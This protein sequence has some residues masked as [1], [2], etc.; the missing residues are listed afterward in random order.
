MSI[1]FRCPLCKK[2]LKVGDR[3]RGQQRPCPGC[4]KTVTIPMTSSRTAGQSGRR[5]A[6][7]SESP[8]DSQA[9]RHSG[10]QAEGNRQHKRLQTTAGQTLW[11]EWSAKLGKRTRPALQ[12][13][14][15]RLSPALTRCGALMEAA[16]KK[17]RSEAAETWQFYAR[18][19]EAF[20][21]FLQ[22]LIGMSHAEPEVRISQHDRTRNCRIRADNWFIRL[23]ECC[24][25]CGEETENDP[26]QKEQSLLDIRRTLE[27]IGGG[28]LAALVFLY[29]DIS[30]WVWLPT[31][32]AGFWLGCRARRRVA[33][34]LVYKLCETHADDKEPPTVRLLR[35]RTRNLILRVGSRK[36][37][38]TAW[39]WFFR[40]PE[41]K[42]PAALPTRNPATDQPSASVGVSS[43][44]SEP[45]P[46]EL[47]PIPLV[48]DVDGDTNIVHRERVYSEDSTST[49]R[50][51]IPDRLPVPE[52]EPSRLEPLDPE[53][54]DPEPAETIAPATAASSPSQ[55]PVTSG[56]ETEQEGTRHRHGSDE[57][58][59][60]VAESSDVVPETVVAA[61]ASLAPNLDAVSDSPIESGPILK[62]QPLPA[63]DGK[64]EEALV[65][66]RSSTGRMDPETIKLVPA[67]LDDDSQ[68]VVI[69]WPVAS[70]ATVTA[71]ILEPEKDTNTYELTG[72]TSPA[73]Q[74]SAPHDN[75]SEPTQ[76]D[77]RVDVEELNKGL[78][79]AWSQLHLDASPCA[80]CG[81]VMPTEEI[82]FSGRIMLL[83]AVQHSP[84]AVAA[85]VQT[86]NVYFQG[87]Y[88][89]TDDVGSFCSSVN[90]IRHTE[91][92]ACH[93]FT[94][95]RCRHR[96][97][98]A[99][100][101]LKCD[102]AGQVS[103]P[104]APQQDAAEVEPTVSSTTAAATTG[105]SKSPAQ[106][107]VDKP[108]VL[109]R[110]TSGLL[111]GSLIPWLAQWRQAEL[112]RRLQPLFRDADER[113]SVD[114]REVSLEALNKAVPTIEKVVEFCESNLAQLEQFRNQPTQFWSL[115]GL[116]V[117]TGGVGL[118]AGLLSGI[119]SRLSYRLREKKYWLAGMLT[120]L[121]GSVNFVFLLAV[122][123][124]LVG[125][126]VF[127]LNQVP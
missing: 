4:G 55:T 13:M 64:E 109:R 108:R 51:L 41:P 74:T 122:Y 34:L 29:Y 3:L 106:D 68:P 103:E 79:N 69:L 43:L 112:T 75:A 83:S 12:A 23:P 86:V 120:F 40:E 37:R 70:E 21:E 77:N 101:C 42:P 30:F 52:T 123:V 114:L 16:W 126:V 65:E 31:I 100:A 88:F 58:S 96:Y 19:R 33:G 7:K 26:I 49:S 119:L 99:G 50:P 20:G 27:W 17:V 113:I 59:D 63:A 127:Y 35:T 25:V 15:K 117:L 80:C 24:A 98:G 39:Q 78:T 45:S 97:Q 54:T 1:Q 93:S 125:A 9:S 60:V 10:G 46:R 92:A 6:G 8:P 71:E 105:E 48:D 82:G 118:S 56:T 66:I 94:C 84:G 121:M 38:R 22:D 57:N 89:S 124:T 28:L 116:A 81:I 87:N 32:V 104:V 53:P 44:P 62:P 90:Q 47:S 11:Q 102:P 18:N 107:K 85:L 61:Q 2:G 115:M 95:V 5:S 91:C 111:L 36:F 72:T 67:L 73:P 14:R 76:P 110:M